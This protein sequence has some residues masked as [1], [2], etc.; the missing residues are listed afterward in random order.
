MEKRKDKKIKKWAICRDMQVGTYDYEDFRGIHF[1][2]DMKKFIGQKLKLERNDMH[3][4]CWNLK[5]DDGIYMFHESW[6]RFIEE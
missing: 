1:G 3:W 6:L 2:V 4:S 5:A